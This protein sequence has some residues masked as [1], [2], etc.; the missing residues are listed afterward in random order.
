MTPPRTAATLFVVLVLVALG[1]AACG[2]ASPYAGV[3][4][5]GPRVIASDPDLGAL[6][7]VADERYRQLE[8]ALASAGADRC[9][10]LCEHLEAICD[11]ADRICELT[12]ERPSEGNFAACDRATGRCRVAEERVPETCVGCTEL[13]SNPE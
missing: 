3:H 13:P 4:D 5:D 9:A 6:D 10:A 1:L 8:A 12:R 11:I 7:L 2:A